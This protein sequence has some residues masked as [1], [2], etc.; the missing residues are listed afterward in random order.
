PASGLRLRR[1]HSSR[2][3]RGSRRRRSRGGRRMLTNVVRKPIKGAGVQPSAHGASLAAVG[4]EA[5]FSVILDGKQVKPEDIF[6]SP[7]NIVRSPMMHRTGRSYH[8]PTGGAIY[9]DTGVIEL[10]T[11]MIEIEPG[12]AARAGRS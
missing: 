7:K 8:L 10:A 6:R 11:P 3:T 5:E 2:R 1:L 9:F 12:C 4:L